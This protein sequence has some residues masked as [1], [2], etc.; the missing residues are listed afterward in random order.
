MQR[1]ARVTRNTVS[2]DVAEAL[3]RILWQ[4]DVREILP[5]VHT[6]TALIVGDGEAPAELEEAEYVASLMP[7]ARVHKL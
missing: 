7:N 2:P 6:P 4:T 1:Y 3:T 5:S